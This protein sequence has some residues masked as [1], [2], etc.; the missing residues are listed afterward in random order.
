MYYPSSLKE[1]NDYIYF[2]CIGSRMF[3]DKNK[4]VT[5]FKLINTEIRLVV[6]RCKVLGAG[7]KNKG[8]KR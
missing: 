4:V 5:D 2:H 7:G 8:V 6:A 1:V 3:S